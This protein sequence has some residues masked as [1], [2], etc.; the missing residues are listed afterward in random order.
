MLTAVS[1]A[2]VL[3]G[4]EL[5]AARRFSFVGIFVFH[6]ECSRLVSPTRGVGGRGAAPSF[7]PRSPQA[8][9]RAHSVV[10]LIGYTLETFDS[11]GDAL[12]AHWSAEGSRVPVQGTHSA[13]RR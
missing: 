12:V 4:S 11:W 10:H 3:V 7:R 1:V 8:F 9:K 6:V 13:G 2:Q 5:E